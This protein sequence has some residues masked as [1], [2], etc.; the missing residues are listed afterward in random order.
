MRRSRLGLLL[1]LALAA[2][3]AFL[4]HE[5]LYWLATSRSC[6]RYDDAG[7]CFERYGVYRWRAASEE[8]FRDGRVILGESRLAHGDSAEWYKDGYVLERSR[9]YF[10]RLIRLDAFGHEGRHVETVLGSAS[11]GT[12]SVLPRNPALDEAKPTAP[13]CR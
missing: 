6:C 8:D 5:E 9:Y 4:V 13:W 10:G 1:L 7:Q 2:L 11:D 3:G 12:E